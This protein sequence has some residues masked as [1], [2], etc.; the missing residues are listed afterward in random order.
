M[1]LSS[2][3][4]PDV[5]LLVKGDAGRL[6]QII[7]NLVGNAIK[8][9]ANGS[10]S[11]HIRKDEEDGQRTTLRFLVHDYG[12][13]IAADKLEMI[14]EPFTQ[15]D[16][17]TTR[18]YG[19]T[20]LG[21]TISRQLAELMGGS[22]GVESA[23]GEG[24]TFWFT[25]VLEKQDE[26]ARPLPIPNPPPLEPLGPKGA[27][28]KPSRV[29]GGRESL[30]DNNVRILLAEDDPINQIVVRSNLSKRGYQV[31][32]VSDGRETLEALETKD[33]GLIL[34]DCMMPVMGGFETTA[35]I[36]DPASKV[37]NHSIPIIALTA[38]AMQ[39]DQAKCLAA[40]MDDYLAKPLEVAELMALLEKWL[41]S[42]SGRAVRSYVSTAPCLSS[43]E[44]FNRDEFV[45]RNMGNLDL[46]RDVAVIFISSAPEYVE[47]IR[48]AVTAQ[49]A[50]VLRQA[51]H[52]LKGSTANLALPLLSETARMIESYAGVDDFEKA[53]HLLP[54]LELQFE[55]ALNAL[56]EMLIT[57]PEGEHQ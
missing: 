56:R 20:G 37:R 19:G 11:L 54:E 9:S 33:Y 3:I 43:A 2:Q 41:P 46:S 31:D 39:D 5:P 40:G 34:M 42:G 6:R 26:A 25:L 57:L 21:L 30:Y 38:S 1:E 18:K 53:A 4:D 55:Q 10:V 16:G 28:T 22:I 35:I 48:A 27:G 32:A 47:S 44:I 17:S 36:R 14:F 29:G 52:K 24:S 49:D 51:A 50:V 12:I 13:G 45:R 7:T 23:E 8:F 15:A